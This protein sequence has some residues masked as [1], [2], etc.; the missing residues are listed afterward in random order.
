MK[1]PALD[2][3]LE[4]QWT[5]YDH[6]NDAKLFVAGPPGS[7]KTSLVVMRA[8][9]LVNQDLSVVVVTRNRM[10]AALADHLGAGAN[11]RS[12][13]MNSFVSRDHRE[14]FNGD[15]PPQPRGPYRYDWDDILPRYDGRGIVPSYDHIIVDEGQNLPPHFFTWARRFGGRYLTVFADEN[16]AS[17]EQT[18]TLVEIATCG[19]LDDPIRLTSNHRNTPEIAAVAEHF[20]RSIGLPPAT[21]IKAPGGEKPRLISVPTWDD[22]ASRVA[23][24][25]R[26]RSESVGVIVRKKEHAVELQNKLRS[27]LGNGFRVD[28]YTSDRPAG[29]ESWIKIREP[30]ITVLTGEAVIGLEFESVFLIDIARSLPCLNAEAR[31][32]MYMLCARAQN[33][34]F[35]VDGLPSLT[36]SQIGA[37]PGSELLER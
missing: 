32:R 28:Y 17:C 5:V 31:R 36:P 19:D 24:R 33:A 34:L 29:V 6:P 15:D 21:V 10:L 27:T 1:L 4:E 14:H 8:Q 12:T 13:T 2:D 22:L 9:F 25:L 35:L 18:S 26:N 3:L 11:F 37:L 7:G 23:T 30:G 16:Q 20:H